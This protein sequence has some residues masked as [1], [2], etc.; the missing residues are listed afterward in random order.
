MH[1]DIRVGC[2]PGVCQQVK[3]GYEDHD[4]WSTKIARS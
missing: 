4:I 2:L 1:D 3:L